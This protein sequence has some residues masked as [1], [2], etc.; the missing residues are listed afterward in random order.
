MQEVDFREVVGL[1]IKILSFFGVLP[2]NTTSIKVFI[3]HIIKVV[4]LTDTLNREEFQPRNDYQREILKKYIELS[5][6]ATA[7]LLLISILTCCFWGIYPFTMVGGPF[8]PLVAYIPYDIDKSPN[9]ELTYLGELIGITVSAFCCLSTDTL[10]TGL[11]MV[12]CAQSM[13][14]CDSL[15]N[16]EEYSKIDSRDKDQNE[17]SL[18]TA[19]IKNLHK[20][21]KQHQCI[22][23]FA[24]KIESIFTVAT[25]GQFIVSVLILCTTLFKLST[26]TEVNLEFL[27]TV[28]YQLCMLIEVFVLCYFGNEATVKYHKLTSSAYHCNWLTANKSF[29][30]QLIFFMTASQKEL[31]VLAG[32]YITLSLETFAYILKSS[33]SYYTVLNQMNSN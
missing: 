32:G 21:V 20:C 30:K 28:L 9:F 13:L 31:K 27:S 15:I 2:L 10:I 23:K 26:V 8:L 33:V 7:V 29:K 11:Y 3:L 24:E 19:M 25:F 6:L 18:N 14:L 5:K 17:N 4:F 16:I 12:L 22:L 1:N